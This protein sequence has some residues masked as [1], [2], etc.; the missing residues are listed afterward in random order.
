MVGVFMSLKN[1]ITFI[2]RRFIV[3]S[4]NIGIKLDTNN[5]VKRIN[6]AIFR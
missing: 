3:N 2:D 4:E 1:Q 6:G 5:V